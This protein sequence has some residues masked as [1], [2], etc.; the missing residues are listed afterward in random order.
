MGLGGS[1]SSAVL[2]P[3]YHAA[4]KGAGVAPKWDTD[5]TSGRGT[6]LTMTKMNC[7]Y[8]ET[9]YVYLTVAGLVTATGD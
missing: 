1:P 8:T 4:D 2:R 9:M 5:N 3:H 6:L 7:P